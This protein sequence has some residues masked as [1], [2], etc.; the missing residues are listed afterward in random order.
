MLS[1]TATALNKATFVSTNLVVNAAQMQKNVQA[2]HGLMLAEALHLALARRLGSAEARQAVDAAIQTARTENRHLID[3]AR[4]QTALDL[5]WDTLH[6]ESAYLG[7]TDALIDR[8]LQA[9][10]EVEAG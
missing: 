2:T 8:V 10:A 9:A 1:L 5:D 6:R 4:E 3:V 7:E